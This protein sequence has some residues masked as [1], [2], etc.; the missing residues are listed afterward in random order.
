MFIG[1]NDRPKNEI[2]FYLIIILLLEGS[3]DSN[4]IKNKFNI[5]TKT[6]YRYMNFIKLLLFDFEFYFIDINYDRYSKL[7]ICRVNSIFKS[8]IYSK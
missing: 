2:I 3:V 6:F 4:E 8:Q 1:Q 5:S 7:H